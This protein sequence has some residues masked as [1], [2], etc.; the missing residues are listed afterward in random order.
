MK[1]RIYRIDV[2]GHCYKVPKRYLQFQASAILLYTNCREF[3]L[4][5]W[6]IDH[7]FK[8]RIHAEQSPGEVFLFQR[9]A[10]VMFK[11]EIS[12]DESTWTPTIK[13]LWLW[14]LDTIDQCLCQNCK[15]KKQLDTKCWTFI[16]V[17]YELLFFLLRKVSELHGCVHADHAA[18][19]PIH[20][21]NIC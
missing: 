13:K 20:S 15:T 17:N 21:C 12:A 7:E 16:D 9:T 3:L 18:R 10:E 1:A 8:I 6:T 11:A 14:C 19:L 5:Y 4:H 2:T